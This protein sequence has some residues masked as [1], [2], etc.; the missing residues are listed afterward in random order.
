M[1]ESVVAKTPPPKK[2]GPPVVIVAAEPPPA[3]PVPKTSMAKASGPLPVPAVPPNHGQ[4]P[5]NNLAALL[6]TA[7]SKSGSVRTS[8]PEPEPEVDGSG[9]DGSDTT[10]IIGGGMV[11]VASETND[12]ENDGGEQMEYPWCVICHE[13]MT[14]PSQNAVVPCGHVFHG[15]CLQHWKDVACISAS[16]ACPLRCHQRVGRGWASVSETV[17]SASLA[18]SSSS[19]VAE[20]PSTHRGQEPD[21]G[22]VLQEDRDEEW[23]M[24]D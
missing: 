15:S 17:G 3:T 20:P 5:A 22:V 13:P 7:A 18:A 6:A 12:C 19:L 21:H 16:N 9:D 14:V 8:M 1:V 10:L 23:A 2:A 4:G 11:A 24:V